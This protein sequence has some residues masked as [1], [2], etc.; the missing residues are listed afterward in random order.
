[1]SSVTPP[2]PSGPDAGP[3][4]DGYH[5][6]DLPAALIAATAALVEEAGPEAFTLRACARRAGV[7][8]AAP[9]H[10]FRDRAG[11]LS[12]YAATI[13]DDFR[14]AMLAR[15]ETA[16][17]D[18]FLRLKAIGAA[19]IDF[20]RARPGAFR[21][22]FRTELLD[23]QHPALREASDRG[24]AVLAMTVA[25]LVRDPSR[26]QPLAVLAWSMVHGFATLVLDGHFVH[27]CPP[28]LEPGSDEWLEEELL[29]SLRPVFALSG[30]PGADG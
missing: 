10:H 29:E 4:G 9:A 23:M 25:T 12:A 30:A 24:F 28:G 22:M 14:A 21:L 27:A 13:F 20:A 2:A 7:S 26:A 11:L 17:D 8:H 3:R 15:L 16:G 19:Y 5:H 18:P 6:G 1:M